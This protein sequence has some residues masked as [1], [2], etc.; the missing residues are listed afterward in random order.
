V[1]RIVRVNVPAGGR[2]RIAWVAD[3]RLGEWMYPCHILAQHAAGMMAHCAVV[4]PHH[5]T[6]V[7]GVGTGDSHAGL[8]EEA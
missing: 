4:R 1:R 3:D 5:G 7:T 6:A 2:A 8:H